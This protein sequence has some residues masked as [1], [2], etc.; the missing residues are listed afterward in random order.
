VNRVCAAGV[1]TSDA[2]DWGC[3]ASTSKCAY[4][5]TCRSNGYTADVNSD[6][7][8][9]KCNA[10]N[11]QWVDGDA[12]KYSNNNTNATSIVTGEPV[13]I[14]ANWTDNLDLNYS[15]LWTN[16]TS[17]NGKNYTTNYG[18][19]M[20]INLTAGQ[21]WSNFTWDNNTFASGVVAW[22]I[23]ANDSGN[24]ENVTS[25]GYFTVYVPDAAF[26]IA[27]P[28]D[29]TFT[30]ITATSE[31]AATQTAPNNISFNF[32]TVP[33][34]WIEPC[35]G[36]SCSGS[37]KQNGANH[38]IYYVNVTGN[39]PIK[40]GIKLN[41]TLTTGLQLGANAS[42][43]GTYNSCQ[44]TLQS[45]GNTYVSL[46][47]DLGV[48]SYANITLYANLTSTSLTPGEKVYEVLINSTAKSYT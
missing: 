45:I 6:G 12:P 36:G 15:W 42:C 25:Q 44:S 24:N 11:N 19:P 33:E 7:Y 29:F 14:Y 41:A 9:E 2:T 21:T 20:D 40:I 31:G 39:V 26:A 32:T 1:C 5:G 30:S 48:S 37:Y 34:Y 43:S 16:E 28:T 10:A 3:C 22:K 27:M 18:S 4:D 38:P 47:D 17:G 35:A 46:V 23:Y 8:L 13:L